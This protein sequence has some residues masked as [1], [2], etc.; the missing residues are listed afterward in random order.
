MLVAV[1]DH[2][3]ATVPAAVA[4][5]VHLGGQ[6]RVGRAHDRAD[7][8]VVL[9]VLDR[10]VEVVPAGVE[11]GDDRL[12]APVAVAV[13]D[14]AP[15]ALGEQL[16]RRTARPPAARPAQGPTPDLGRTVRHR[17]VRRAAPPDR[18]RSRSRESA[19]RATLGPRP[20]AFVAHLLAF[21]D[22]TDSPPWPLRC[23]SAS[24]GWTRSWLLD[25]FGDRALLGQP[26]SSSSSSAG[27]SSRSCPATPCCSRSACFIATGATCRSSTSSCCAACVLFVAAFLGNVVGYEIGARGRATA[28]R[29]RRPDHQEEVLRPDPRRS[30]TSTATRPWSSAGSCRSCAP[31]SPWS[32]ASAGWSRR[33][34]FVWSAVGACPVGRGDHACS[35]TSSARRSR[36][37]D[38]LE[39]AILLV[40]L[41]SVLPMVY[42]FVKHRREARAVAAESG[43]R[44]GRHLGRRRRPAVEQAR[45][46]LLRSTGEAVTHACRGS[47]LG[48]Q[49]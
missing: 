34:F 23:C 10:D 22:V 30:S 18:S 3:A 1:G 29:A 48:V 44:L 41:V 16:G 43:R 21:I 31:T 46:H 39:F 37:D 24:S 4:D 49:G 40:V 28:L 42:E 25:Q 38:N 27:C 26:R 47:T 14:V 35:A 6:E 36:A 8:E 13:D 7:V 19:M 11:V 15:V 33:R 32:P 2:R 9:P 12:H 17:V 5:D 20:G 45:P